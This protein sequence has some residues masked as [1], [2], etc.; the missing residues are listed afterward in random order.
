M[1]RCCGSLGGAWRLLAL[2]HEDTDSLKSV[3][4]AGRPQKHHGL[5]D[6]GV[7][8]A[9]VLAELEPAGQLRA[10]WLLS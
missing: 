9:V 1:K 3:D 10:R 2:G 8:H 7:G 5:A 6:Y 4:Q